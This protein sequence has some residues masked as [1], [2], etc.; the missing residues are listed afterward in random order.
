MKH[1][2]TTFLVVLSLLS[3]SCKEQQ[4][5][6][7]NTDKQQSYGPRVIPINYDS[8]Y[9]LDN[10]PAYK[11]FEFY[12]SFLVGVALQQVPMVVDIE[13][14]V[15]DAIEKF[16]DVIFKEIDGL[17]IGVD[18]YN[19]KADDTPNPLIII[20]HG[21]YWKAG[22]KS[23]HTQQAI[24]FVKLGYTAASVNY[25]L[26]D[27]YKFPSNIEDVRDCLLFLTENAEKYKIDA[28]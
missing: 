1:I 9:Q 5:V 2:N 12:G 4:S 27:K 3:I 6:E 21:G 15:P 18:I 13:H 8:L 16:E 24:E 14:P 17:E 10:P 11:P 19:V 26:S 7:L 25:R 22:D 23:D 20:I 28:S